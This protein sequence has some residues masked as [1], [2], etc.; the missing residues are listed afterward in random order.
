MRFPY[1]YF[2]FFPQVSSSKFL[3]AVNYNNVPN[4]AK[5]WTFYSYLRNYWNEL[6]GSC[7]FLMYCTTINFSIFCFSYFP[8]LST[9]ENE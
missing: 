6:F 5:N 1:F 8:S 2:T 7:I 4:E 9:G 3:M